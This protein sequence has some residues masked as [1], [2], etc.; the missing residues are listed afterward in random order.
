VPGLGGMAMP[1]CMKV[2]ESGV[3]MLPGTNMRKGG[4]GPLSDHCPVMAA[5]WGRSCGADGADSPATLP[6]TARL[7]LDRR[8]CTAQHGS[9]ST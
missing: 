5:C 1:F 6:C 3:C 4:G 9:V 7:P 8:R 2:G